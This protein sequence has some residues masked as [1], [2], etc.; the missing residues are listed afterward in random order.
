MSRLAGKICLV[1]GASSGMG[2]ETALRAAAEGADVIVAARRVHD[3][4]A[5]AQRIRDAGGRATALELDGTSP[6]SIER[7]FE[8]IHATHGRLDG[9]FNNLGATYGDSLL[10][11]TPERRW[12]DTLATNL[13]A[14]FLL[15]KAEVPLLRA[16]GG[17][18]IVNN[19]S[20]AGLRGVAR[21]ADY[22]AAKWGLI[23]LTRSAAL[24]YA[25]DGIRVN[26]IAP[27]IIRTEKFEQFEQRMPQMF[28]QLR[29]ATP[30]GR[31]G[32]MHEV[33]SLVTWLLS[34]EARYLNG[35]TIPIDAGRTAG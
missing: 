17:G 15:M 18:A 21:M 26:V 23:G 22:A 2:R 32:E 16:A 12:H 20:A 24:E 6:T 34:D 30:G 11:E 29:Q 33:A 35:A 9:A 7:A 3:C 28:E 5:V 4:E 1:V 27:G 8:R 25:S 13:T 14:P 31:F 10:H 19:S